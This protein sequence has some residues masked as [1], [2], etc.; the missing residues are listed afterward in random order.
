L[1][2][3]IHDVRI[4]DTHLLVGVTDE[5]RW[6]AE[7]A[8]GGSGADAKTF[9][10]VQVQPGFEQIGLHVE[11][12]DPLRMTV[13][14]RLPALLEI[15]WQAHAAGWSIQEARQQLIGRPVSAPATP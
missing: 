5:N 3:I 1:S 13:M 8:A 2:L 7:R 15:A 11:R 6:R 4:I 9:L 10:W 14:R 12:T